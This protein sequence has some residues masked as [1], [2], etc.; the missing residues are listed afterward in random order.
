M[1]VQIYDR[2][3]LANL[4][5]RCICTEDGVDKPLFFGIVDS[6]TRDYSDTYRD[7]IAYDM[8]Y[9]YSKKNGAWAWNLFWT[10]WKQQYGRDTCGL[11]SLRFLLVTQY[12]NIDVGSTLILTTLPDSYRI[13][14]YSIDIDSISITAMLSMLF[15]TCG[16][17]VYF[18]RE[19]VMQFK[20]LQIYEGAEEPPSLEGEY[21]K[22]NTTFEEA[23]VADYT[24]VQ[25]YD[26]LGNLIYDTDPTPEE[27]RGDTQPYVIR[28]NLIVQGMATSDVELLADY[29]LS[30]L[31]RLRYTPGTVALIVSELDIEIGDK[32]STSQGD[33]FAFQNSL[34]GPLLVNQTL[35]A[36]ANLRND[37][38]NV[39]TSFATA[40]LQ[41][42]GGSGGGIIDIMSNIVICAG[43]ITV[44]AFQATL[45]IHTFV[46]HRN[47]YVSNVTYDNTYIED[48]STSSDV[49]SMALQLKTEYDQEGQVAS[50]DS[51]YL[52][53][54]EF[55][56]TDFQENIYMKV[57]D[58]G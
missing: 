18:D 9:Y 28:D 53:V 26:V 57:Y 2:S 56:D 42:G 54:V 36:E 49:E 58:E 5:M 29:V 33:F 7:I 27:E 52:A 16:Y 14:H 51:G 6:C 34:S 13:V 30:Q 10:N 48:I 19:G 15:A 32:Y 40:E 23:P 3:E 8:S 21:E 44:G 43:I 22:E 25:I 11:A 35:K 55:D 39:P 46:D 41:K 12:Y 20:L 38:V 31:N 4:F 17:Y 50:V 45:G 24:N 47:I 1:E 37:E